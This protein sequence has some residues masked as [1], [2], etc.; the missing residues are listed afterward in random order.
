MKYNVN[1]NGFYGEFGGAFVPETLGR[2]LEVLKRDYLR[3]IQEKSFQ[4]ELRLLLRD[5][6]GRPTPLYH[7]KRLSE[8][9]GA[10]VYLKREDLCHT[11]AHKLNNAVGQ[12][13]LAKRLGKKRVIA[14]TGAGQHGV[15]TAT[16]C[17]LLDMPCTIYMGETDM[18]RQFLNVQ[19]MKML[20]ANVEAVT[21]GTKTLTEAVDAALKD[22]CENSDDTFYLLGSAVGP[23]PY[24]DMVTHFQSVISEEIKKQLKEQEG[25]ETPD[26][27]IACVGGGSN[28]AGTFFHYLDDNRVQ[29]VQAEAAGLGVATDKN[30]ATLHNGKI[31]VFQGSKILYLQDD[32]GR[33]L[34]PYSIS[35]GL[36][37]PGV[38]PL[39]C[40]LATTGRSQAVAITDQEALQAALQLTRLEGVIPAIESSHALAALSK[41]NFKPTDVVVVTV[42]GR[43]DKDMET[44]SNY[45]CR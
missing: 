14:E 22:F 4:E 12:I 7:A 44:Y 45:F 5:F 9:V 32:K 13:L 36:D 3:I 41:I 43:G 2:S 37:Y 24:P 39:H 1:E 20:G 15:A 29:L 31:G 23:A 17:T 19:R 35:A 26:Y 8:A 6:V 28:A 10:K 21:Y 33:A 18:N 25:T 16:V 27:L 34:D 11:G 30:A 40:H 38:G 42:S